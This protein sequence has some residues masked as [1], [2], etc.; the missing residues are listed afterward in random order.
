MTPRKPSS[1][2]RRTMPPGPPPAPVDISHGERLASVESEVRQVWR[3]VERLTEAMQATADALRGAH[4]KLT[5][6][7]SIGTEVKELSAEV[8]ELSQ[9][10]RKFNSWLDRG[11]GIKGAVVTLV[12]V[13]VAL[14]GLVGAWKTVKDAF[15]PGVMKWLGWG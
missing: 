7:Q 6:L 10:V 11:M 12:A 2:S 3:E 4:G 15:G 14:A 1:K 5:E 8:K 9:A 13:F